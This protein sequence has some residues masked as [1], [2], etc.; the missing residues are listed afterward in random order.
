VREFVAPLIAAVGAPLALPRPVAA[1]TAR[2][3]G[4]GKRIGRAC[5]T[6]PNWTPA[7]CPALTSGTG[8]QAVG[9]GIPVRRFLGSALRRAVLRQDFTAAAVRAGAGYRSTS[10]NAERRRVRWD[11]CGRS[12]WYRRRGRGYPAIE[13]SYRSPNNHHVRCRGFRPEQKY[14]SKRTNLQ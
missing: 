5:S 9:L 4:R 1:Q 6:G 10:E 13:P 3:G 11:C 7:A 8:E 2:G 12:P 14:R